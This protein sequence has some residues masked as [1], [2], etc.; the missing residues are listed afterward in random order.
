[1]LQAQGKAP[2]LSLWR[3][4]IKYHIYQL[5]VFRA[6]LK[7]GTEIGK[8]AK[9]YMDKGLLVPDEVVDKIV[10][11]RLGEPDCVNGFI[12]DGYP[13][14]I[15]QAEALS[16]ITDLDYVIDIVVGKDIV[17]KRI[18]GRRMCTCGA[19]YNTN[20]YSSQL[21]EKCGKQLYQ[22]DDDKEETVLKRLEVYEKN[23]SPLIEYYQNKGL[24]IQIDGSESV[25]KTFENLQK[26]LATK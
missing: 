14:T 4:I 17:V 11:Q 7:A 3:T 23:T 1:V 25:E 15:P 18:S 5:D 16:K 21:C 22:R 12:L 19:T 24:L 2:K 6:H 13:R 10:E 9:S 26:T 20:S 8:L